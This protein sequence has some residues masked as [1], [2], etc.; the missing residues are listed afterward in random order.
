MHKVIR[1]LATAYQPPFNNTTLQLRIYPKGSPQLRGHVYR[2]STVTKHLT[3]DGVLRVTMQSSY[4]PSAKLRGIRP[5]VIVSKHTF[6]VGETK[7]RKV[8]LTI[9]GI[10]ERKFEIAVQQNAPTES[11]RP[12]R[13]G[14]PRPSR[15]GH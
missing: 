6:D 14:C 10:L 9:V 4:E 11:T 15:R 12:R 13:T 3:A 7:I 2:L 5:N 8:E 1:V